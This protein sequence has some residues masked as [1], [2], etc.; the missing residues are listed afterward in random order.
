MTTP[1]VGD[2]LTAQHFDYTHHG[3]YVGHGQV[4]HYQGPSS[5]DGQACQIILSTF[6]DFH[7]NQPLRVIAHPDRP[8]SREAC[9]VWAFSWASMTTTCSLIT[10]STSSCGASRGGMIHPR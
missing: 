9:A 1:A 3:I 5:G 10:A 6:D 7:G 8:F 2:H 4:I